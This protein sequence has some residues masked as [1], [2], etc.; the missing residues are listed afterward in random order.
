MYDINIKE[1]RITP[2]NSFQPWHGINS[3]IFINMSSDGVLPTKLFRNRKKLHCLNLLIT[4]ASTPVPYTLPT[5]IFG[6]F[7]ILGTLVFYFAKSAN[8]RNAAESDTR[9]LTTLTRTETPE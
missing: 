1:S 4:L 3:V 5:D 2:K 8:A 6:T 9:A 7:V